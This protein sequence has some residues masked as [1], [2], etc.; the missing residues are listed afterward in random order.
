MCFKQGLQSV[1]EVYVQTLVFVEG[2]GFPIGGAARHAA[3]RQASV[4]E[5]FWRFGFSFFFFLIVEY[6]RVVFPLWMFWVVILFHGLR[7][8][9]VLFVSFFIHK[10]FITDVQMCHQCVIVIFSV[11]CHCCSCLFF[12]FP[13][14]RLVLPLSIQL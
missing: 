3:G 7:I 4:G 1:R 12:S 9:M 8:S 10:H 5:S 13:V 2:F 11:S 6:T 14:R